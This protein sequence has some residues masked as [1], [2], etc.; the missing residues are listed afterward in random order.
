MKKACKTTVSLLLTLLMLLGAMPLAFAAGD[1]VHIKTLE[2]FQTFVAGDATADAILETDLDL[3]EWTTAFTDGYSGTF[4]GDGHSITYTKTNPTGNFHSLFKILNEGGAIKNL[5]VKGSMAFN[6]ARTYNAPFVYE[7]HGTIEN[8]TNEM[9]ISHTGTKNCQYNAGIAAK[10]YGT[11]KNCTNKAD[12]S[13]RNYAG[14][15]V[16]QNMGGD[17]IGCVN[18]GAIT[19]TNVAGYAGGILAAVGANDSTDNVLI[20]NCVNNGNVTGGTGDYGFAGGIIGQINIASSYVTY[21]SKPTLTV[22]GCSNTGT[23]TAGGGTDEIVGKNNNP[24]NCALTVEAGAPAHTHTYDEGTVTKEP[25][26]TEEGVMTYTCTS[27]DAGTEG[28][29]KTEVIQKTPHTPGEWVPDTYEGTET[30]V[31]KC[32]SCGTVL[33]VDGDGAVA[34]LNNA[35]Q[36]LADHWFR[37]TPKFGKDT[38]VNT[39]IAGALEGY[40]FGG[41][42]ASVVSAENP[43]DGT[44][45]IADN[46]DIRYFYDDPNGSRMLWSAQIPVS[47]ALAKDSVS[48]PYSANAVLNW[49]ADKAAAAVETQI[50]SKVTADVVKGEND[51]LSAATETLVLPKAVKDADEKYILWSLISWTSSDPNVIVIDDSAQNSADT[52]FEPY[53]GILKR[54]MEDKTVTLTATFSFQ[55]TSYDE[56]PITVTKTFDVTVKGIGDELRGIMQAQLD[57]NYTADK[58]T[59][60]GLKTPIE[61]ANVTYDVQLLLPKTAGIPDA[62]NYSFTTVSNDESVVK[63]LGARAWVYRPLPG[64]AAKTV[65]LTVTMKHKDYSDIAVSKDIVLTVAPLTQAEIDAQVALMEQAKAAFFD[66]LN[67]GANESADKVTQNLSAFYGAVPGENGKLV[68]KYTYQ[69]S[70]DAGIQA[71]SIDPFHPSEKWDR[72]QSSDPDVITHENLLVTP[73]KENTVVTIYACLSSTAFERYAELYPDD[74]RFDKLYRQEVSVD[75]TVPGTDPTPQTPDTPVTPDTSSDDSAKIDIFAKLSAFFG[76]IFKLLP[77]FLEYF[78]Y[79]I[80]L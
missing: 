61:P 43:E 14:G 50:A 40:G 31:K 38:N 5:T 77:K 62:Q 46:G 72:F 67:N 3:G 10:N 78:I 4:D 6:N 11:V 64:E 74:S 36:A 51:S 34:F 28:H 21:Q 48:I 71:V 22:K 12:I 35:K 76:W 25:S 63:I 17:I 56:D 53:K 66:G 44:A 29:T 54:G 20:E 26:C 49:D 73:Q 79:F 47:F 45:A 69:D 52:L 9:S 75:V 19:A 24:D 33:D 60:S 32:T 8:C 59:Y 16:A 41:I 27:C 7:N 57:A 68:W 55:R 15:I 37:L 39:M 2:D 23:L 58:L 70:V 42:T 65:T 18:N 1:P 30:Y 80:T 13:V